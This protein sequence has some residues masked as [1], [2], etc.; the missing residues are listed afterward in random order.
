M[1]KK[2]GY[3]RSEDTAERM[4]KLRKKL[5]S[6]AMDLNEMGAADLKAK[7]VECQ[8]NLVEQQREM[9]TDTDLLTAKDALAHEMAPY[10][11]AKQR[12]THVMGYCTL[13]LEELGK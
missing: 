7:I 10:K 4:A 13:R 5:R 2:K 8:A 1:P 9:A 11:E 12:L 6:E 3:D